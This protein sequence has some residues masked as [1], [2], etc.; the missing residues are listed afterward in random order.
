MEAREGS[1]APQVYITRQLQ[2][3]PTM[4]VFQ[5]KP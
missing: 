5:K 3:H 1:D 2:R 4:R